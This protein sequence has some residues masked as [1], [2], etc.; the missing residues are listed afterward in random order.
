MPRCVKL[1]RKHRQVCVG[2]LDTSIDIQGRSLDDDIDSVE[3]EGFTTLFS[4]WAMVETLRGVFVVDGVNGG[5]I[6]ATHRFTIRFPDSV[7]SGENWILSKNQRY[8]ILD[9]EDYEE[10][11]EFLAILC[12]KRGVDTQ[13]ASDA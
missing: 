1:K 8:R 7:I 11:G 10:R 9:Q 5:D 2:D 6:E 4:P 3:V 12:T 13:G